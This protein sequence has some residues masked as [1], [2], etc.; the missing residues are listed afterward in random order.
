MMLC[1]S[2]NA[3]ADDVLAALGD[4]HPIPLGASFTMRSSSVV[5]PGHTVRE[6]Q[7]DIRT[8]EPQAARSLDL[9]SGGLI[10]RGSPPWV[11]IRS[12]T[13]HPRRA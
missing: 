8:Q 12:S 9:L 1:P 2:P 4:E 13:R 10:A 7:R 5:G 11:G 6:R 3:H